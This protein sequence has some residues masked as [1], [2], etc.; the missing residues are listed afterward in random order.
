LLVARQ[1]DAGQTNQQT[2]HVPD[3]NSPAIMADPNG[4]NSVTAHVD[5]DAIHVDPV[6]KAQTSL[7]TIKK[8]YLLNSGQSTAD[9]ITL[10]STVENLRVC[11]D[12]TGAIPGANCSN[13]NVVAMTPGDRVVLTVTALDKSSPNPALV[14]V[15]PSTLI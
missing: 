7:A 5:V 15:A 14:P 11:A 1:D 4:T 12:A 2:V 10:V 6:T 13:V 9:T 3:P 8:T